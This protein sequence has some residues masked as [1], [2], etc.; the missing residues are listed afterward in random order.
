MVSQRCEGDGLIVFAPS[1]TRSIRLDLGGQSI[2]G[3]GRGVGV[4]VLR[5]G[6]DGAIIVGGDDGSK[7]TIANF[8]TGVRAGGLRS[9]Q[10]LRDV[11]VTGN[12]RDGVRMRSS[13][14]LVSG[15]GAA[16]NGR[17]GVKIGGH[18]PRLEDVEANENGRFGVRVGARRAVVDAS[19][20][21]NR[22]GDLSGHDDVTSGR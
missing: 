11:Q 19:A 21:G 12:A 1:D 10:E 18:D 2:V 13:D 14:G 16:R 9:V 5:G 20:S 4:R 8:T 15:V 7:A 3:Q 17:D 22:R 6:S